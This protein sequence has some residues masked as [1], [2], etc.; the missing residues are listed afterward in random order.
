MEKEQRVKKNPRFEYKEGERI[1]TDQTNVSGKPG[2]KWPARQREE[3]EE[4]RQ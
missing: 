3:E 1:Q 4:E 2:V